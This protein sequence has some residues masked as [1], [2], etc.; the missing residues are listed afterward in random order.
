MT[1]I[2]QEPQLMTPAQ[3]SEYLQLSEV[4]LRRWRREGKGP[5]PHFLSPG[6]IRYRRDNVEQWVADT[7]YPFPSNIDWSTTT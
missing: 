6:T 2:D 1:A 4:T 3:L 5:T 7:A